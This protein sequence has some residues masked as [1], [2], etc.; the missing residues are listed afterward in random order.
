MRQKEASKHLLSPERGSPVAAPLEL[1]SEDF[2]PPCLMFP[3]STPG[4]LRGHWL[5]EAEGLT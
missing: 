1:L 2:P 3:R 4:W 5:C